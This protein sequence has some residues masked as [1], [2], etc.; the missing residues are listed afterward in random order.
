L[1]FTYCIRYILDKLHREVGYPDRGLEVQQMLRTLLRTTIV[2][3]VAF[4]LAEAPENTVFLL[5]VCAETETEK[6]AEA[7]DCFL[8][9]QIR[10]LGSTTYITRDRTIKTTKKDCEARGG[11]PMA[12]IEPEAEIPGGEPTEQDIHSPK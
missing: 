1:Q 3:V 5:K 9:G 12:P 6:G 10:P 11:R 8:P 4:L 2:L 7:V